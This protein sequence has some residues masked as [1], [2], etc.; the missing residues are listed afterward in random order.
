M[1][2]AVDDPDGVVACVLWWSVNGGAWTSDPMTTAGG[3]RFNGTIPGQARGAAVQFYV[4]GIDTR[5]AASTFPARGRDARALYR[6]DDGQADLDLLHNLRIIMTP[7]DTDFLHLDTNVMSNDRLGATVV[8]DENRVFYDVGVRLRSSERGRLHASRVGFNV[9]FHPDDPFR[10][11]HTSVAIDRAGGWGLGLTS[12]QDEI[13]IKHIMLRAGHVPAMYDD[14]V[15]VIAPRS[16]QTGPALLMMARFNSVF[17]DSQWENG[18][19]G[20]VHNY[21]LIYYPTTTT[22]GDPE[23]L[24]RPQPDTVTGVDLHDLGNDK[25][26]YRWFFNLENHRARDDYSRLMEMCTTFSKRGAALEEAAWEVLDVDEWMRTFAVYSLCGVNDTYMYGNYHN[27][28]HYVRPGD[29]RVLVFAWD[30][31]W[32]WTSGRQTQALWSTQSNLRYVIELTP[33]TRMYYRHLLDLID[34][35]YNRA[36]LDPW[37]AHYGMLANKNYSGISSFVG[38]RMNYVLGQIPAAPDFEITTAG[39]A[40]FSVDTTSREIEGRSPFQVAEIHLNGAPV[41]H[42][43]TSTTRWSVDVPLAPGPNELL[44]EGVN[45]YS[46]VIASDTITVTSTLDYTPPKIHMVSPSQGPSSGGTDVQLVGENFEPEIRVRFGGVDATAVEYKGDAQ[47]IATSPR[48]E[49]QVAIEVENPDGLTG[50]APTP[51]T[52]IP[53]EEVFVRG[54]TNADAEYNL[55]DAIYILMYLFQ[56]GDKPPCLDAADGND[57]GAV[58]IS[59]PIR[60]LGHL[61]VS[62][63]PPPPPY[64]TIPAACGPD[65]TPD[66]LKCAAYVPCE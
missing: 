36:Y 33:F 11:V 18:A 60:L 27:N 42:D 28:K 14:M 8:Y 2:V 41:A 13:V 38:E 61:F 65:P 59:D 57:D 58:D 20:N 44:F 34:T 39:G 9:G 43:W 22:D 35:S 47:I 46:E 64:G 29:Q 1:S 52:Y 62:E 5:G 7:E 16:A 45:T 26:L 63:A 24:K 17:L 30:M 19:E 54:D 10:G 49:G 32:C 6:V 21:E 53:V 66:E 40:N 3:D 25:E 50:T 23:S 4:E 31:D 12:S 15:R 55:G 51:F 48:G 56:N 37:I